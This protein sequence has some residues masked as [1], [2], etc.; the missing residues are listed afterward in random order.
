MTVKQ[1]IEHLSEMDPDLPVIVM[2]DQEGNGYKHLRVV[3]DFCAVHNLEEFNLEVGI[4]KLTP[5]LKKQGFSEEDVAP[6][7]CVVLGP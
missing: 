7:R 3:D 1:L 4:P 5:K 6:H 2:E